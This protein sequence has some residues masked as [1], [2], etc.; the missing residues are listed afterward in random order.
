MG[1]KKIDNMIELFRKELP[2][3]FALPEIDDRTGGGVKRRTLQNLK[4]S[5]EA[6]E[7]LFIK[8]GSR[9]TLVLRDP[10][11]EWWGNRLANG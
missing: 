11:L 1:E 7:D 4:S 9:K 6:P 8:D 2:P 3:A 10:F 5:G